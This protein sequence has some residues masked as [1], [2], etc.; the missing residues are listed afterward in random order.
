MRCKRARIARA[1]VAAAVLAGCDGPHSSLA[2]AGR[3]AE[4]IATLFWWMSGGAAI[5]WLAVSGLAIYA[6]VV[7]PTRHHPRRAAFVVSVALLVAVWSNLG[8]PI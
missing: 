8:K 1:S 7:Q 4:S 6:I 2:P 3:S 5:V